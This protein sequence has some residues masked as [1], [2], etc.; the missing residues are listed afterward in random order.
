MVGDGSNAAF[1]FTY[2][3]SLFRLRPVSPFEEMGAYEALW[4]RT[5]MTT[6]SLAQLFRDHPSSLPSDF[7]SPSEAREHAEFVIR[8]F[9]K[10]K[11]RDFGVQ[12]FEAGSYPN[13]LRDAQHPIQLLYYQGTWDLVN[14]ASI[15]VVGTR[16]ATALGLAL[17]K[18]WVRELVRDGFTIVSGLAAGIDRVVHDTTIKEEGRTIAV[19]GTPLS[20]AY[21]KVHT[22]LQRYIAE[23]FL[24]ISQVP[25]QRYQSQSFRFNRFFF[26]ERN[27][28][29]SALTQATIIIEAGETSG[30]MHQAR[31]AINQ[32]RKL[33]ILDHCFHDK[34]LTWPKRFQLQGAIRVKEYSEIA[35]HLT[36]TIY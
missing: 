9:E 34:S 24:V 2:G 16:Q 31:A 15:A 32:G 29:M 13:K 35:E 18:E 19:I 12:V 3:E 11:I 21:P 14:T 25:L 8:N 28:T 5:N 17:A 33:F 36:S 4:C 20:H 30:T 7:V 26:P 23:H 27:V 10:A 6:K 1:Q 22:E